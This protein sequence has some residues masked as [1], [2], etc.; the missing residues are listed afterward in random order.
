MYKVRYCTV[1]S[2][3]TKIR[4]KIEVQNVI[5]ACVVWGA[6]RWPYSVPLKN[7]F[8]DFTKLYLNYFKS[9]IKK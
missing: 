5:I 3:V 9:Q 1:Y 2:N 7:S 8:F 6:N 4:N